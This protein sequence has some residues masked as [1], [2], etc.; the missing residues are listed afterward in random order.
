MTVVITRPQHQAENLAALIRS[1]G[2]ECIVFPAIKITFLQ[3][4]SELHKL[5][6]FDYVIF[7]SAN[8]V[9]SI[10]PL[11][12]KNSSARVIAQGPGTALAVEKNNIEVH[13]APAL[14]SAEGILQ[15]AELQQL[16]G[17]SVLICCGASSDSAPLLRGELMKRG[18]SD[19][20]EWVC[21]R[22][23]MPHY[24]QSEIERVCQRRIRCVISTSLQG[25]KNLC[26]IFS[27]NQVTLA[28]LK[29]TPLLVI[30]AKMKEYALRHNFQMVTLASNASDMAVMAEIEKLSSEGDKPL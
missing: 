4:A 3:N 15:I 25:L 21:Y 10:A 16:H 28:W 7:L 23:D 8:A 12:P 24:S 6:D 1:R 26:E 2:G 20:Q 27:V 13:A 18:A 30:S 9:K 5:G 22:G 29:Q 14:Y 17:K 11:W 19:V